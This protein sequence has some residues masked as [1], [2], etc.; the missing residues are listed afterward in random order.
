MIGDQ[1]G[2]SGEMKKVLMSLLIPLT[3]W[4]VEFNPNV[5]VIIA[6]S[7]QKL[8]DITVGNDGTIYVIWADTRYGTNLYFAKSTDHGETFT[9]GVQVNDEIGQVVTLTSNQPK[10][11]EYDGMLYVFWADQRAGY[12]HTDIY[13]SKSTDGGATWSSGFSVGNGFKFNLY[14]EVEIDP[15]GTIHLVYYVYSTSTLE[16][17]SVEYRKSTNGGN[18]FS[19]QTTVSNYSGSKPCEC[20]PADIVILPD[21]NKI[22][23]FRDDNDN[24]RDIFGT[25]SQAGSDYWGDLFQISY[26]DFVI[27]YCPSSGPSLDNMESTV[28]LG[29]MVGINEVPRTFLK[30]STDG[31]EIFGDSISVDPSVE[32]DVIQDYPSLAMTSDGMVHIAWEDHRDGSDIYYGSMMAGESELSSIQILNDDGSG[33]SQREVRMVNGNDGFVYAVWTDKRNG[34]DDIYF[35]TN[36]SQVVVEE[37]QPPIPI[38]PVLHQNFPNPFNPETVIRFELSGREMITVTVHD[39]LGREIKKLVNGE[40][41]SGSYEVLWDGKDIGGS[42]VSPGVYFYRLT[43][44]SSFQTRKMV[45]IK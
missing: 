32:S 8:P 3:I 31:G 38:T 30:I 1:S 39:I 42:M 5:P 9:E 27:S 6:E 37:T 33:E 4:A 36:Y 2:R 12:Y 45:L 25:R 10:I 41:V 15:G 17:E 16:F 19:F 21:G 26:E 18:S 7:T 22:A 23:A 11:A 14:P 43:S 34:D 24:I 13:S 20:C 28:A 44:G 35:A 29:Y 40:L